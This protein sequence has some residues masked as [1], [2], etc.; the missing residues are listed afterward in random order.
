MTPT[1]ITLHRAATDNAGGFQDSGTHLKVGDAVEAGT[2]SAVA[3][4]ELL[5]SHGATGH[6]PK[7]VAASAK[8]PAA[9]KPA[10]KKSA[11]TKA[12]A[13]TPTPTP[14]PTPAASGSSANGD[15]EAK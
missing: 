8:K 7:S 13:P 10:A 11:A 12:P 9:K 3:A 15:T 4:R 14:T 5:D 6:Y 1:S 2:I